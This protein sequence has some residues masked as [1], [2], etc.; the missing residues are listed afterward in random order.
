M[1][2]EKDHIHFKLINIAERLAEYE[3][4]FIVIG[5]WAIDC[6]YPEIQYRTEDIDFI[7]MK[8]KENYKK[9]AAALNSLEVR[10][11]IRKIPKPE[12][13]R[14]TA[15]ML[16]SKDYWRFHTESGLIDVMPTAGIISG[17]KM[18]AK[19]ARLA[20]DTKHEIWI[21]DPKIVYISKL[22]TDRKKDEKVLNALKEAIVKEDGTYIRD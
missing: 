1:N 11:T 14:L 4:D 20:K 21:A 17:F 15:E 22:H 10:R 19:N 9:L 6:A 2:D 12:P 3:V 16:D 8:D 5:G 18:L 13:E 7:V